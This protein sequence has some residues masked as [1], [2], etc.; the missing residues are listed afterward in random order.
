MPIFVFGKYGKFWSDKFYKLTGIFRCVL[1]QIEH[2]VRQRRVFAY[3]IS[4]WGE[5]GDNNF[6]GRVFDADLFEYRTPLLKLSQRS[7][8]KPDILLVRVYLLLDGFENI[9]SALNPEFGLAVKWRNY[10]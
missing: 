9:F 3:L 10:P 7:K 1:R 2:V 8:M 5:K 4:R 6:F